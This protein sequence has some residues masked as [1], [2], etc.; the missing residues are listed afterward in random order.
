MGQA[1]LFCFLGRPLGPHVAL[2]GQGGESL[3]L[4]AIAP[5]GDAALD[6]SPRGNQFGAPLR[7]GDVGRARHARAAPDPHRTRA[8]A[9]L[10]QAAEAN[11]SRAAKGRRLG[12]LA[13]G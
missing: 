11:S 13:R 6:A 5:A 8:D 12:K 9:P 2:Q 3:A 10:P 4:T 7:P 1:S